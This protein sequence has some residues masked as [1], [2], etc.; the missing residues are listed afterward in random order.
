M[1]K[2][3]KHRAKKDICKLKKA[4]DDIKQNYNSL[5]QV[6]KFTPYSWTQCRC[7]MSVKSVGHRKLEYSHKLSSTAIHVMQNHMESKEVSFPLPDCK[8]AGKR[9]MRTSVKNALN[10][11]NISE[12]TKRPLSLATLYHYQPKHVK[13]KGKIPL[14]QSCCE[15]CL[16]FD[17]IANQTS[18]Y[19]NGTNKDLNEAI[20]STLC[21]YTGRFPNIECILHIVCVPIARPPMD[22]CHF[23][24]T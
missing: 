16:N 21:K 8:F 5:R 4:V 23:L 22:K 9:F 24:P 3:G 14:R 2:V 10:M 20:D 1:L 18:K 17:Y 19:L 15:R 13:L 12:E 11:Y 6:S 7:F